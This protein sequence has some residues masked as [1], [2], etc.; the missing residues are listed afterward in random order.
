MVEMDGKDRTKEQRV[1]ELITQAGL[2]KHPLLSRHLSI[3]KPWSHVY[4]TPH[5]L[6]AAEPPALFEEKCDTYT[7]NG[8]IIRWPVVEV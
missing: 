7:S 5:L 3:E 1:H 2:M 8:K 4:M 6:A